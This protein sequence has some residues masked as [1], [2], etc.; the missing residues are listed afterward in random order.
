MR[1][2]AKVLIL[3]LGSLNVGQAVEVPFAATDASKIEISRT[4][5][6]EIAEI[7]LAGGLPVLA[8][9]IY[10]DILLDSDISPELERRVQIGLVKSHL[11]Q[12]KFESAKALIVDICNRIF[13][14]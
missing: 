14:N 13:N 6:I 4:Q 10:A 7:L 9:E 5:D 11:A 1:I 8:T 3:A 12:D 2:L